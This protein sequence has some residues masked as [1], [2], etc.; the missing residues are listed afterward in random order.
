MT[1]LPNKPLQPSHSAVTPRA[2]ARVAPAGGRLNGG[3]SRTGWG[4][5]G[6]MAMM[7]VLAASGSALGQEPLIVVSRPTVVAFFPPVSEEELAKHPDTN[8]A[9]ADFQVYA[10]RVRG[11]LTAAGVDFQ[12]VF[13]HSFRIQTGKRVT[14]FKPGPIEI[15][16]YFVAPTKKAITD[17]GVMT[18][19][20]LLAAVY[21]HLG[22]VASPPKS[23][24]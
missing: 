9:L 2:G 7:V 15:G 11:P 20:D 12:V 10:E 23:T 13:A 4:K 5:T 16:Y 3:V 19:V 18:D 24:K 8:E 6:L 14:V 22:V 21:K 1:A 17:Y